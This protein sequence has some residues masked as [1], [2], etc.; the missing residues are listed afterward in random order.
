MRVGLGQ[1][2]PTDAVP[3]PNEKLPKTDEFS[4]TFEREPLNLEPL[5]TFNLPDTNLLDVRTAKRFALGGA[6]SMELRVDVF[7]A[8]NVTTIKQRVARSGADFLR[9]FTGEA[10]AATVI[11]L[12][13]IVQ[14]G[15]SFSF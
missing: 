7:N 14:L 1:R 3:N 11:V 2:L 5:G 4:L 10:A 6:R 9:P 12:P 15:V 8:M 13:R